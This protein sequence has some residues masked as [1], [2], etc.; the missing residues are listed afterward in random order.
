MFDL[1]SASGNTFAFAW[2]TLPAGADG[3]GWARGL[4]PRLGLDGLFLL[5]R[6]VAGLPWTMEHWD[7]DG[8]STFCSNGTRAALALPGAPPPGAAPIQVRSNRELLALR[9]DGDEVALRMPSGP[10]TGFRPVPPALAQDLARDVA[11]PH[12]FAWI[13]NPQLVIEHPDLDGLDLAAAAPPLRRHP[14]LPEGTN[15]NFIQVVAPG[16]A[17]IRSW[18]RGVEGETRCCGTGCA[19]AG[20][21]LARRT[22]LTAWRL[23]PQGEPVRIAVQGE[24]EG[25]RELWLSGPVQCRGQVAADRSLLS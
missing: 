12:A 7:A 18:E 5:D 10:G 4:C 11:R 20:A 8:A 9:R 2:G 17:R 15:V 24:G 6:P 22:G 14:S 16:I 3:P 23:L 13:G 21:W 1:A 25:W 19:V